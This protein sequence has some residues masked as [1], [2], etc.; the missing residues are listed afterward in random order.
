MLP[1]GD[2]DDVLSRLREP[3]AEIAAHAARSDNRHFH[4]C[5][6]PFTE[7]SPIGIVTG[8]DRYV[9]SNSR[10]RQWVSRVKYTAAT[11]RQELRNSQRNAAE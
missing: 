6:S 4:G 5:P 3:P 10:K 11:D 9:S 8:P 2:E 1:A 7:S